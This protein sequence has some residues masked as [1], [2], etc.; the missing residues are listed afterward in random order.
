MP[1]CTRW[2]RAQTREQLIDATHAL[3]RVLMHGYYVVPQW[4]S[5]AHRVA[6]K[7]GLDWPKTLPLYYGRG[8]LDHVDVV[9]HS[10]RRGSLT[11]RCRT[12]TVSA[13]IQ[14][15]ACRTGNAAMWSY[16]LKRLLLM[17][18]TVLG[19]LTLTFAVIQFVPGGPV[20]QMA[21]ELRKGARAGCRSV[22][23]RIAASTR[24]R[25]RSSKR[26]M[27]STSRRSD[28]TAD[29]Q[30]L[31]D[32]RSRAELFPSPKR[33]VV[34]RSKLPV[35]ISI[36]LWT[37][38]LTYLISVPLGI[39]K[40]V[41]NGSHFDFVTEP[42]RADRLRDSWLRPRGAAARAVRRRLVPATVSAARSHVG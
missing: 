19:V 35:S 34:G 24:S 14:C 9:V 39:A 18:P 40:A 27:A 6:F 10:R 38:F 25:S 37:F 41:R 2:L 33:L 8:R 29:A 28:A 1:S 30:A 42:R 20:E 11:S 13:V 3:D 4:Y 22:C 12:S 17:I 7:R 36:G 31:C 15:I 16:I 5:A 23:A 26:C 32:L 21:H